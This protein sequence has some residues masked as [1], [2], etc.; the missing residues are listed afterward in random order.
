MSTT[1]TSSATVPAAPE[2]VYAAM[3]DW[4]R[5]PS[6]MEGVEAVRADGPTR[7]GAQ[8]VLTARGRE[9]RA[10]VV[11]AVPGARLVLR[12]AQGPVRAT[13]T[14][15]L[16]P[17]DAGAATALTLGVRCRTVGLL[18]PLS[19]LVRQVVWRTDRGQPAALA[20]LMR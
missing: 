18:R 12:S 17:V 11:E 15:D 8:L 6:W 10:E 13:Y 9:R 5:A 2:E 3:T 1:R 19:P 16:R 20:T 14:Y 4:D 7:T